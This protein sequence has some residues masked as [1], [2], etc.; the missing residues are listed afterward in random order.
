MLFIRVIYVPKMQGYR[1][2]EM[3]KGK[4]IKQ[5]VI[6]LKKARLTISEKIIEKSIKK[7]KEGDCL[8]IKAA[9]PQEDLKIMS[10]ICLTPWLQN[11]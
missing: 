5:E 7:N 11:A 9:F 6:I 4:K 2:I 3:Q 10:L 8:I 1:T